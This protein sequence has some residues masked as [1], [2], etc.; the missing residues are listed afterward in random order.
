MGLPARLNSNSLFLYF[1]LFLVKSMTYVLPHFTLT[2]F[3]W[4]QCNQLLRSGWS[5][6]STCSRVRP[7]T[8]YYSILYIL[9]CTV[10]DGRGGSSGS[11]VYNG[12]CGC[13]V[14]VVMKVVEVSV[15]VSVEVSR[16]ELGIIS[17]TFTLLD[18]KE[19][20]KS[21]NVG[22][23]YLKMVGDMTCKGGSLSLGNK[24]GQY[25]GLV[26][27]PSS[28]SVIAAVWTP[29]SVL[30]QGRLRRPYSQRG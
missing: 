10:G 14:V 29:V 13:D 19:W 20:D 7:V 2:L 27:L 22:V 28:M 4:K 23:I 12:T 11:S 17:P 6:H 21:Y 8:T 24:H 3:L 16:L 30:P 5:L 1:T 18:A 9:A 25:S 15:S 26:F